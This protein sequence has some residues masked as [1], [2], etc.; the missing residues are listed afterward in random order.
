M[1]WEHG[2]VLKIQSL[3]AS[4]K[5]LPL[6]SSVM[7][8][9]S[10]FISSATWVPSLE[11]TEEGKE[12][13]ESDCREYVPICVMG[14]WTQSLQSAESCHFWI[15]FHRHCLSS[16]FWNMPFSPSTDLSL[17]FTL[18][19]LRGKPHYLAYLPPFLR[20]SLKCDFLQKYLSC[21]KMPGALFLP[22]STTSII[23]LGYSG[24]SHSSILWDM[25][26]VSNPA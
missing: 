17:P 11:L 10:S 16:H 1:K 21:T 9:A 25:V 15:L 18:L 4:S 12:R 22:H 2:E 5:T 14:S 6:S 19:E 26:S 24:C 3:P 23:E 20:V 13:T 8:K 7:G